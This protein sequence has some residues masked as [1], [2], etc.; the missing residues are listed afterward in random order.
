MWC[1]CVC[2]LFLFF[3]LKK[4]DFYLIHVISLSFVQENGAN[5]FS[6]DGNQSFTVGYYRTD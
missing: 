2:A 4:K 3:K 5:G 1:V 6:S